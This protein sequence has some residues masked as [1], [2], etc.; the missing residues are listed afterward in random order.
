MFSTLESDVKFT[1]YRLRILLSAPERTKEDE[2]LIAVLQERLAR[3]T[4][5][6]EHDLVAA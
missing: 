4:V 1:V 5:M 3:L 2:V 6:A